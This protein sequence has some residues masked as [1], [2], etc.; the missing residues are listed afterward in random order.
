MKEELIKGAITL[1]TGIAGQ[2]P[3]I[4]TVTGLYPLSLYQPLIYRGQEWFLII[5]LMV[6]VVGTIAVL[7]SL[8]RALC[9]IVPVFLILAGIVYWIFVSFPVGSPL[10]PINWI[11]SY[12]LWALLFAAIA[13]LALMV[14]RAWSAAP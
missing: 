9:V 5:P 2:A 8:S 13:G 4:S 11:L 14:Q 3:W 6:G 1:V 7:I 12:C 10:H